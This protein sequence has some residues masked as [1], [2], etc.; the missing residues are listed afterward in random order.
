MCVLGRE[1]Q[2]STKEPERSCAWLRLCGMKAG[3]SARASRA[4]ARITHLANPRDEMVDLAMEFTKRSSVSGDYYEF[5]VFQGATF[6]AAVDAARRYD[7]TDMRF[8]A[9]DSFDGL[10]S[11][12][13]V[14]VE[15]FAHFAEGDYTASRQRFD[16]HLLRRRVPLDRVT[17]TQ[18]WFS[19]T[20]TEATS[21]RLRLTRA[22]VVWVD[23]DLYEST[24]PVLSFIGPLL[25][26]GTVIVFDDWFCFHARPD[27]GEQRAVA[28]WLEAEPGFRMVDYRNVG[29]HGKA[30]IFHR[31]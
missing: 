15:G 5:G 3:I 11:P 31:T 16:E 1:N 27:R 2:A 28:E 9:F 24:V 20:L 13:G 12:A 19:D 6:A 30:F 21:R 7:L 25:Q 8:H 18:G 4:V 14:D 10:P 17:V 26:D 23:C 29:W 22:A